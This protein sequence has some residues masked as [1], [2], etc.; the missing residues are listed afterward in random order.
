MKLSLKTIIPIIYFV[1]FLMIGISIYKHYGLSWDEPIQKG[2]GEIIWNYIADH[3]EQLLTYRDRHYGA[4]FELVLYASEKT[5]HLTD[6]Q[7]IYHSR[8][9]ITFI[10]FYISVIFF[11]LLCLFFLKDW[12]LALLGCTMLILSPRIFAHAFYNSKDIPFLS[13]FII[14]MFTLVKFADKKTWFWALIHAVTTSICIDIRILGI[15]ILPLTFSMMFFNSLFKKEKFSIFIRNHFLTYIVGSFIFT[16][17]FQ[18]PL[19]NDPIKSFVAAFIVMAKF[20]WGQSVL[21]DGEIIKATKL[22]FSYIPIW[23]SI[24]TPLVYLFFF[25]VGIIDFV[26]KVISRKNRAYAE[27]HP[28]VLPLLWFFVPLLSIIVFRSTVYDAWRQ[29]FFI[30]PALLL[31]AILGI[32]FSYKV[33][34]KLIQSLSFRFIK[35][36]S[37]VFVAIIFSPIIFS[38]IT[39][40]PYQNVYFNKLVGGISGARFNFEMDYWGLS[41]KQALEYILKHDQSDS[42]K[43]YAD[44][45]PARTNRFLLSPEQQ[46]RLSYVKLRE[47]ADYIFG[48]YR[49]RKNEY[50]YKNEFYSVRVKGAKILSVFKK[51]KGQTILSTPVKIGQK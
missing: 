6:T 9:L 24:T 29:M 10:Y 27:F 15:L 16:I 14:A 8:H 26:V 37:F 40:H 18:P 4:F 45:T 23:I 34:L 50:H 3:D 30:Y 20:P 46:A 48:G 12:R 21:F 38:M 33:F 44:T 36:T 25:L 31:L 49:T 5:F 32:R 11:Y 35:A 39:Y 2:Y 51:N 7:K 28:F 41:N 47:E 22:P 17:L 42:I 19:W 1:F 43:I 13:S